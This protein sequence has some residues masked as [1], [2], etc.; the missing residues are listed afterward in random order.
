MNANGAN[1][2][3]R[4]HHHLEEGDG[5]MSGV[6]QVDNNEWNGDITIS[7][8]ESFSFSDDSAFEGMYSMRTQQMVTMELTRRIQTI[9][10]KSQ[11]VSHMI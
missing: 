6:F 11:T 5:T 10:L 2:N 7:D 4:D 8:I 1:H 9:L 3:D